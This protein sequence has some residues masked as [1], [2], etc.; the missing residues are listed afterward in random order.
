MWK[1]QTVRVL[2]N[3]IGRNIQL[4]RACHDGI[5]GCGVI[6]VLVLNASVDGGERSASTL[7]VVK[8]STVYTE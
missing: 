7:F 5:Q 2:I 4:S 8:E 1:G 3:I 6:A